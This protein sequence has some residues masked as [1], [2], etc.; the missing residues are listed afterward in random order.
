MESLILAHVKWFVD[1]TG[2]YPFDWGF[3]FRDGY[4]LLLAVPVAMMAAFRVAEKRFRSPVIRRLQP[5]ARLVPDI[6]RFVAVLLGTSYLALAVLDSYLSPGLLVHSGGTV[7]GLVAVCEG[8]VGVWLISGFA[9]RQAALAATALWLALGFLVGPVAVLESIHL[10]G[11]ALF[12]VVA[13]P[14]AGPCLGTTR[15]IDPLRLR[16]AVLPLKLGIGISFIVVAFTEKL[17][18]PSIAQAFLSNHQSF[19]VMATLK[20]WPHPETFVLA[21]G[22]VELTFGMLI[23]SGALPQVAAVVVGGPFIATLFALGREELIGHLPIVAGLIVILVYGSHEMTATGVS[24]FR[25]RRLPA[26]SPVRRVIVL[27]TP[28]E[29]ESLEPEVAPSHAATTG[30]AV[31]E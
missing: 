3:A 11:L 1:R 8:I 28:E 14:T 19:N 5:L 16:L 26:R 9:T 17:A 29:Q 12:L 31:G 25:L 6:P 24:S 4:F 18:H 7:R 23:I 20:L 27:T 2:D 15:S 10:L 22:I 30:A 13:C 21:M